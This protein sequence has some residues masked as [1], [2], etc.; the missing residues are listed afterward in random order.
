MAMSDSSGGSGDAS[1]K[2]K[3]AQYNAAKLNQPR[4]N[5]AERLQPSG[6]QHVKSCEQ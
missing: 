4:Q 5:I 6:Y 2:G 1:V 3:T